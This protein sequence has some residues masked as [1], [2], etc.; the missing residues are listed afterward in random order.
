MTCMISVEEARKAILARIEVLP[1][2]K[3]F[4][5][6]ASGRCLA[7]DVVSSVDIPP[8]DNSAMDGYAVNIKDIVSVPF[9]LPVSQNIP[10][11]ATP[12]N[13]KKGTAAKIMTGAPVPVG[14][15]AVVMK[16]DTEETPGRV[17]IRKKPG[18]NENIRFK[19]EDIEKGTVVLRN[20]AMISPSHAGLL[21]SIRKSLVYC[22]QV[23]RIAILT[24]G[25]ELEDLDEVSSSGKIA[26]SNAYTLISLIRQAGGEPVNLGIARDDRIHLEKCLSAAGRADLIVTCGGVS[27]GDYDLIKDIMTSGDNSMEF[28]KV[29]MKPGKPLAFGKIAGR[30]AIGLPGNPAAVFAG[31]FQFVRPAL[32]KMAGAERLSLPRIKARLKGTIKKKTD[33]SSYI[34]A[35]LSLWPEP[36]VTPSLRHDKGP[37]SGVASANCFIVLPRGTLIA[38]KD[39]FVECEIFNHLTL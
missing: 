38:E 4:M 32:L 15:D 9:S 20:G 21:A 28:W 3:I 36:E 33:A 24:T 29:A 26:S 30:P 31:F 13:L 35:A 6:E 11:G 18:K 27:V 19:G 10:A 37:L 1:A 39:T 5:N 12:S 34:M 22:R 23:P 16:E 25:N 2:E 14:A 7:E 17:I 8:W